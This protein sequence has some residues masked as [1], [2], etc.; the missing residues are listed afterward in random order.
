MASE[1]STADGK[2]RPSHAR[3]GHLESTEDTRLSNIPSRAR[4][5]PPINRDAIQNMNN[6]ITQLTTIVAQIATMLN[7]VNMVPI[8]S[9][10]QELGANIPQPRETKE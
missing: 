9:A 4:G 1:A 2:P 6:C 10:M 3:T 8:P 5:H 7:Q